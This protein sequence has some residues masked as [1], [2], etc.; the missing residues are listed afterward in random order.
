[1]SHVDE[2]IRRVF[3]LLGYWL[4]RFRGQAIA[5]AVARYTDAF[6]RRLDNVN[7]NAESN[8]E[9]RFL[10]M[11]SCIHPRCVFDVGAHEGQWTLR[12]LAMYPQCTVHAF[13]IMPSSFQKLK[14]ATA[15]LSA[16]VV[17]NPWG[18]SD[19]PGH[20]E[21]YASDDD[22]STATAYPIRGVAEHDA[23][24]TTRLQGT[25]RRA[26]DYVRGHRIE[27]V[28][29]LKIDVEGMDLRVIKGFGDELRRV[30]VIQFEYGVF[31]I[32]SRD[33]LGD[34]WVYLTDRGYA[35]GKIYPR[36]VDFFQYHY[37]RENFLGNNYVAVRREEQALI[38]QLAHGGG[39]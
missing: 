25:V 21:L 39:R 13:E 16:Q 37:D 6:R 1:M 30:R 19:S 34:F 20:V 33:L 14:Q 5:D 31:N 32:S 11:M 2:F 17:L 12:L 3:A 18:L 9:L 36:S 24:Y 27:T 29:L 23:F 4:C 15:A 35:V 26:S 28:D 8:G 22:S 38:V 10:Q 7:F